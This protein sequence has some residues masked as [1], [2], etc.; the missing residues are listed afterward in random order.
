MQYN[1]RLYNTSRLSQAYYRY[2]EVA[3]GYWLTHGNT[4]YNSGD[5]VTYGLLLGG[6]VDSTFDLKRPNFQ[7]EIVYFLYVSDGV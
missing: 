2:F 3:L 5:F 4:S 6:Q 7:G 1:P